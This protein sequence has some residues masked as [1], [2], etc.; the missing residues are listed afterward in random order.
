[1]NSPIF[2]ALGLAGLVLLALEPAERFPDRVPWLVPVFFR[3][4]VVGPVTH[5]RDGDTI[6]VGGRAIRFGSL[7]CAERGT[8]EGQ[9]ARATMR[10][11]AGGKALTCRLNGERS[12]DRWIGSCRLPTGEDLAGVMIARGQ[13]WRYW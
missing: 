13:C 7:D 8:A 9:L 5:V 10:G 2:L 3:E 12:Y 1:M 6:E 4:Q 11:L